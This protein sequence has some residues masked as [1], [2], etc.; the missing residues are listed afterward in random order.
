MGPIWVLSAPDGHHVGP[1][2][3]AIRDAFKSV[4]VLLLQKSNYLK[5]LWKHKT[6]A[7][8]WLS[9]NTIYLITHQYG[10]IMLSVS[11][12]KCISEW[13][14]SSYVKRK[15]G[16]VMWPEVGPRCFVP[17]PDSALL[18]LTIAHT[19]YVYEHKLQ[20]RHNEHDDA[21]NHQ[22]LHCLLNCWFRRRSKKTSKL[23]VTGLC[24]GNSPSPLNSPHKRPVARKFFHL[25]TSSWS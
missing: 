3:L 19:W 14:V 15:Y 4:V 8:S 20:W 7:I 21:S 25:M 17:P 16:A 1:T 18:R 2:N 11:V 9:I 12:W 22:R 24:A 23:S 6:Q 10:S 5:V 13:A